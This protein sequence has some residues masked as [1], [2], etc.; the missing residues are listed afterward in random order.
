MQI[1]EL[2]TAWKNYE[3]KITVSNRLNEQLIL[4]M[5]KE[6]SRSRIARIRQ[7]NLFYLG[8]MIL[9]LILLAAIFAGNP[10]DFKYE[11]QYIP[12]GLLVA[13]VLLAVYKILR[14]L[15]RFD[16]DI[17]NDGLSVFLKKTIDAYNKNKKVESWFGILLFSA[18]A[19]TVF[20]FLPSKL[21]HKPLW[22]ALTETF[23]MMLI[24][25]L[26]YVAAFRLGV[27]KNRDSDAFKNDWKELNE[28][29]SI[30]SELSDQ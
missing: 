16:T 3:Q 26:I 2:K 21:E 10:F 30:S 24:T 25:V 27:F 9:V 7:K 28:L 18:G 6:R 1:E 17:T 20:S 4:S 15:R 29:K 12:Y 5:L 19:L 22:Q 8:W 23:V 13:G 11:V 14:D